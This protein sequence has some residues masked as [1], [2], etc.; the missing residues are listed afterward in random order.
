MSET[1][2]NYKYP[3]GIYRLEILSNTLAQNDRQTYIVLSCKVLAIKKGDSQK[4]VAGK[5]RT[6]K[7][8]TTEASIE[9]TKS[10]LQFAQFPAGTSVSRLH[11]DHNEHH[12]LAGVQFDAS[13]RIN[14]RGYDEFSALQQNGG[15]NGNAWMDKLQKPER[16]DL[17][18]LDDLFGVAVTPRS[19]PTTQQP[20]QTENT[21]QDQTGA[22]ATP[23]R[24]P[25]W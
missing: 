3:D 25:R 24:K 7:L 11:K 22:A 16:S 21:P 13:C 17:M 4:F 20:T 2:S 9:R 5:F 18:K 19:K 8:W 6:V 10:F 12:S 23:A 1:K 14:D 15:G